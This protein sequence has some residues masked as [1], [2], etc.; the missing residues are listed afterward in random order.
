L[1]VPCTFA[2]R[3]V[4]DGTSDVALAGLL[5]HVAPPFAETLPGGHGLSAVWVPSGAVQ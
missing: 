3:R 2:F 5:L 1:K 4:V